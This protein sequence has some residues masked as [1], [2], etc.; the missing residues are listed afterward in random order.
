MCSEVDESEERGE[1]DRDMLLQKD[2]DGDVPLVI[3]PHR[4]Q[5]D[6]EPLPSSDDFSVRNSCSDGDLQSP[7]PDTEAAGV[8]VRGPAKREGW[9]KSRSIHSVQGCSKFGAEL[10]ERG[11]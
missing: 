2:V 6:G 10:P 5:D 4:S 11:G 7:S 9:W 1:S 3:L 8:N